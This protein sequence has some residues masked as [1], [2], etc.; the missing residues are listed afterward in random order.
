M[1]GQKIL[2]AS[3]V[4]NASG[5]PVATFRHENLLDSER[6]EGGIP[7]QTKSSFFILRLILIPI[8]RQRHLMFD[9]DAPLLASAHGA[10]F[11][12]HACSR[13]FLRFDG[14]WMALTPEQL[15]GLGNTLGN[16]LNC[17][18]KAHHLSAGMLLR[19][20]QGETRLALTESLALELHTLI[21]DTLLLR[22]AQEAIQTQKFP[23][24]T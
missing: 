16:I 6:E 19:S 1:G 18:F 21:N 9:L 22:E 3:K 8:L 4:F 5:W 12:D 24:N 13:L 23:E 14:A 17:P 7:L 10:A 20:A 2:P 15:R 11:Q